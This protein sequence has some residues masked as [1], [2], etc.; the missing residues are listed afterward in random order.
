MMDQAKIERYWQAYLATLPDYAAAREQGYVAE[1]FGDNPDLANRL[2]SLI[3]AGT[4]TAT[5]SALWE[6]EAEDKPI[7]EAGL[8]TIVLDG[9]DEPLCII[10]TTEVTI[11]RYDEVDAIFAAEEGEGDR[12]LEYWRTAHWNFFSR[13]L[14]RIGKQA[15]LDMPLVCE[16]FRVVYSG[17][18][19]Q[20]A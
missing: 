18:E 19:P 13:T 16:R 4:K 15:T 2:G 11:R 9:A 6:W 7:A 17:T 8:M 14:P 3:V 10:E 1:Q 5:C 12:S 20:T